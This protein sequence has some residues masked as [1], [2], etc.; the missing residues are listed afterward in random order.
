MIPVL[1]CSE[2]KKERKNEQIVTFS[3]RDKTKVLLDSEKDKVLYDAASATYQRTGTIPSNVNRG[4]DLFV[5]ELPDGRAIFYFLHWSRWQ[6]ESSYIER[7]DGGRAMSFVEENIDSFDDDES[8]E[9]Q[10]FHLYDPSSVV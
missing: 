8:K 3:E 5:R 6:G 10:K 7:I 1:D 2:R 4:I 9:L